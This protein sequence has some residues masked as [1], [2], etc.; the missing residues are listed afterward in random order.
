MQPKDAQ[1]KGPNKMAAREAQLVCLPFNVLH[2]L[3]V[4]LVSIRNRYFLLLNRL[5]GVLDNLANL[6]QV[7]VGIV[8]HE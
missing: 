6:R 2:R 4:D 1:L 7:L 3:F 5:V 8:A